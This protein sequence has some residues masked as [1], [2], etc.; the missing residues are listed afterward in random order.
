MPITPWSNTEFRRTAAIMHAT[1]PTIGAKMIAQRASSIVAERASGT[2]A[3]QVPRSSAPEIASKHA[4]DRCCTGPR[5]TVEPV[6]P[7][8]FVPCRVDAAL[9]RHVSMG[10]LNKPDQEEREKVI[11]INVDDE[12]DAGEQ[13]T[14]H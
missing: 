9:A 8:A 11:L 5:S 3:T 14:N 13:E 7:E 2:R 1:I 6:F 12:R 4:A 10:S